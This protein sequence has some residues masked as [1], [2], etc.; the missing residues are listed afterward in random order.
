MIVF[1]YCSLIVES[2][3]NTVVRGKGT[4]KKLCT[5]EEEGGSAP[6]EGGKTC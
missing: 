6:Q 1:I 5:T 2:K 4:R 3:E